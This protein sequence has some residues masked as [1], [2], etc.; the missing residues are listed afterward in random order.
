[1]ESH[2][3]EARPRGCVDDEADVGVIELVAAKPE[4]EES[5]AFWAIADQLIETV[6]A[7]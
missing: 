1:M 2:M 7:E 6:L 4:G 3:A 5:Q